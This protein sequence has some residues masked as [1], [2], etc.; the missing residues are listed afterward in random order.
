M[1]THLFQ[2]KGESTWYVR[3]VVPEDVRHAFGGRVTVTRTTGT[4]NKSKAMERRHAILAEWQGVIDAARAGKASELEDTLDLASQ[5]GI[6]HAA[7]I[8]G[9]I[10]DVLTGSGEQ[11]SSLEGVE[12]LVKEISKA[13][14][15]GHIPNDGAIALLRM[16]KDAIELREA[17]TSEVPDAEK[18]QLLSS[19]RTSHMAEV[20]RSAVDSEPDLS[21][22]TKAQALAVYQSPK[23]YKPRSPI[24]TARLDS[25]RVH[26]ERKG[27]ASKT[28]DQMCKR[29]ALF[30]DYLSRTGSPIN[31]DIVSAYLDQ[32][33]DKAGT[34]LTSKTKKQHTWSGNTFWKWAIKH[35]PDWREQYKGQ[36][37]PFADHDLPVIK[38]ES[39]SWAAFKKADV[40]RLHAMA[41]EKKDQPL[42][43]LIKIGAFT[44][45]RLEEIGRIHRD[46]ISFTD[47]VP[48]AFAITE[49]K[50]AAGVRDV[51]VHPAIAGLFTQLLEG[52]TD[53]YLMPGRSLDESNKYG[54]RLDAVGKR[55]GRL[56]TTAQFG[57]EF[58]FHSIRKTA[59]TLVHQAGADVS[60]MPG[61]FGHETGLITFDLY[62]DGPSLEQKRKV[63][64]LL[65]FDFG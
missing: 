6:S 25:F 43:D 19:F 21:P 57:K 2:K 38:G 5:S 29:V 51:P 35:D 50:T 33:T 8:S 47:G 15:D 1:A 64:E 58:V 34:P 11:S 40:E 55:F 49:S 62:S 22:A 9:A 31:F 42:A 54:H 10:S 20:F 37:S 53:G 56:K 45:A 12:E 46:N 32:L 65:A 30:S 14:S 44:G 24:T 7:M 27:T 61:L 36:A 17:H 39:V 26:L 13:A 59:I 4:S 48:I 23:A 28:I 52:S 18:I 41:L 63:I 16:L 3:R 60:V